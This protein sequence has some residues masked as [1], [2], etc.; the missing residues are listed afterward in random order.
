MLREAASGPER[1]SALLR[2]H[3]LPALAGEA[4]SVLQVNVGYFCNMACRHCHVDAGPLRSERMSPAT[5]ERI[6]ELMASSPTLRTLDLTGGAPELHEVFRPLVLGAR[7]LGLR[8][9]DRCNLTVLL[10]PGQ[11]TLADFLAG[12]RVQVVASLPCYTEANVDRQRGNGAFRKSIEALHLLNGLGYGRPGSGLD[13]DLVFN[14][15]GPALPPDQTRLEEEYKIRL[16]K[17]F[18]IRFN[19]LL[20]LTNMPIKRFL[21]QLRH[22]EREAAYLE[23]LAQAFN[24]GTL[25]GLMCRNHLSVNW[26]GAI[27]DCDFNQVLDLPSGGIASIGSIGSFEELARRQIRTGDHCLGC[28]AGCGSSCGGALVQDAARESV[29]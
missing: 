14:P 15:G 23:L 20:T 10:E 29:G 8:V 3:G 7:K 27:Y 4:L 18:G 22:Q 25:P 24:P 12:N 16:A 21:E 2:A 1:F 19:R 5:A 28:T 26:Q 13:L 6:L 11:E 17:D 9:L